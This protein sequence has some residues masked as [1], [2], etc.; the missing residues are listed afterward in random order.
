VELF[1]KMEFDLLLIL[2]PLKDLLL[3]KKIVKKSIIFQIIFIDEE[4]EH[5]L[6][7]ILLQKK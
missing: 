4:Q 1:I 3:H 7:E 6:I 5:L 2:E